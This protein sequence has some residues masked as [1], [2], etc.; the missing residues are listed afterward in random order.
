MI[1]H[2]ITGMFGA[3]QVFSSSKYSQELEN[4]ARS[5]EID[6]FESL[7][8]DLKKITKLIKNHIQSIL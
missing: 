1:S 5:G 3:I 8:Q 6:R 7:F 2:K 4:A